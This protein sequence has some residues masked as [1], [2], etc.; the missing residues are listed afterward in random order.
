MHAA[1][2]VGFGLSAYFEAGRIEHPSGA[3]K[4]YGLTAESGRRFS[5]RFCPDCGTL[6]FWLLE[7]SPDLIGAAGGT[8]DPPTFRFP[9]TRE[10]F[11]RSAAPFV[12]T[13]IPAKP[14]TTAR[15][16]PVCADPLAMRGG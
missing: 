14:E 15:H 8:L 5:T 2:R 3:L 6:V 10:I 13:D 1:D 16:A 4:D 7:L 12:P 11:T 9:V